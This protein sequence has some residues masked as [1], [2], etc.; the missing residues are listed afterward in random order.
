M[1][2]DDQEKDRREEEVHQPVGYEDDAADDDHQGND[3]GWGIELQTVAQL[4]CLHSQQQ[5]TGDGHKQPK[6]RVD[7]LGAQL[8]IFV[9]VPE[10]ANHQEVENGSRQNG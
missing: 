5:G 1:S 3:E 10:E 4:I 7:M 6:E 9:P 8:H 2:Q